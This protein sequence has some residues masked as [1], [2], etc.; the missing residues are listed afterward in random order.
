MSAPQ[1]IEQFDL[2]RG[3]ARLV[4]RRVAFWKNVHAQAHIGRHDTR[5][6]DETGDHRRIDLGRRKAQ[7]LGAH[8]RH[9][10]LH[11]RAAMGGDAGL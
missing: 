2:D 11:R 9:L 7:G 1:N 5:A 4:R 10:G 6:K 3:I 8:H